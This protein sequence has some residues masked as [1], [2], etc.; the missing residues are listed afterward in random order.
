MSDLN[1]TVKDKSKA[2]GGV[3]MLFKDK[4]CLIRSR[5]VEVQH[6]NL[7]WEY[8]VSFVIALAPKL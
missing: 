6:P 8:S 3:A 4:L 7:I 5:W 1:L 2:N